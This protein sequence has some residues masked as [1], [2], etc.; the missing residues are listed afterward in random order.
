MN[1]LDYILEILEESL[2]KN[3]DKQ[4]TISHLINI[5]RMAKRKYEDEDQQIDMEGY[6]DDIY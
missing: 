5:I 1:E 6:K 2:K 4:L 3:G